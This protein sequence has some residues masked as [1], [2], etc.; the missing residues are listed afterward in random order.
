MFYCNLIKYIKS[1]ERFLLKTLKKILPTP[2]FL[3]VVYGL[4]LAVF[5]RSSSL[6][7]SDHK[8]L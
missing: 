8:S 3:M 6:D 5:M 2:I 4:F 7:F 1:R